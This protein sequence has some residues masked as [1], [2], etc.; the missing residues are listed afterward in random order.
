[1]PVANLTKAVIKTVTL[2]VPLEMDISTGG[3]VKNFAYFAWRTGF[4][5]S[6]PKGFIQKAQEFYERVKSRVDR[7]EV[8]EVERKSLANLRIEL[9]KIVDSIVE[10]VR[11]SKD[12]LYTDYL[13]TRV[14][15]VL[16]E[17]ACVAVGIQLK[18]YGTDL[19]NYRNIA[20]AVLGIPV[21][22]T[23]ASAVIDVAKIA[24]NITIA[25]NSSIASPA[26]QGVSMVSES[27]RHSITNLRQQLPLQNVV[28]APLSLLASG[29]RMLVTPPIQRSN[30]L[31]PLEQ[32]QAPV[33]A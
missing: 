1:M 9:D 16:L 26:L 28:Q 30:G 33:F 18:A 7:A 10:E 21:M 14:D 2:G 15:G 5:V 20:G 4:P 12:G 25:L 32:Q 8:K 24:N 3:A 23:V 29:Q 13:K 11:M 17:D 31:Q 6:M 27:A 22:P 19:I